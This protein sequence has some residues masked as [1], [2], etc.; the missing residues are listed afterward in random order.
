VYCGARKKKSMPGRRGFMPGIK[1]VHA[2]DRR[3]LE[4]G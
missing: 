1:R 2:K 4:N 3:V